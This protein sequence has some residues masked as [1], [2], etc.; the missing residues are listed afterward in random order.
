MVNSLFWKIFKIV[1]N[2][3]QQCLLLLK[4]LCFHLKNPAVSTFWEPHIKSELRVHTT[5]SL[6]NAHFDIITITMEV[7]SRVAA[8]GPR[9]KVNPIFNAAQPH[10]HHWLY[11]TLQGTFFLCTSGPELYNLKNK[12]KCELMKNRYFIPKKKTV[13]NNLTKLPNWK[14]PCID[15][16]SMRGEECTLTSNACHLPNSN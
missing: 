2:S 11:Q 4:L 7:G 16:P 14:V 13:H 5:S 8:D 10:P 6:Y 12:E 3:D 15:Y 9:S 1:S